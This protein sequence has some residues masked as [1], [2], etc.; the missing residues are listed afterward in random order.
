[1]SRI[2]FTGG[3]APLHAGIHPPLPLG[4]EAGTPRTR[5]P[6]GADPPDQRQAPPFPP[7]LPPEQCMRGDTGNKQAVR[8]LLECN[9]VV[10]IFCPNVKCNV[11][12]Y[13]ECCQILPP[14]LLNKDVPDIHRLSNRKWVLTMCTTGNL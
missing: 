5:H 9:L 7:P 13:V 11:A 14:F 10:H 6:P 2:L 3:S 12:L 8:I 1:M 4:P